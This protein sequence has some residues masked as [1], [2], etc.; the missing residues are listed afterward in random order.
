MLRIPC[1]RRKWRS[2]RS[3]MPRKYALAK[4]GACGYCPGCKVLKI[5]RR[6]QDVPRLRS[7]ED[8]LRGAMYPGS[9]LQ[10][11]QSV[12]KSPLQRR[13]PSPSGCRSRIQGFLG[14]GGWGGGKGGGGEGRERRGRVHTGLFLD[15]C[16]VGVGYPFW[17]TRHMHL[18]VGCC[19]AEA[20]KVQGRGGA[21]W[22]VL[23][24]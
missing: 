1:F 24:C 7:P 15:F 19:L 2:I 22:P 9:C 10:R 11:M 23:P 17:T 21:T 13:L 8:K 6:S 5:P 3:Q 12:A 18:P 20:G 16:E 4:L 14:L